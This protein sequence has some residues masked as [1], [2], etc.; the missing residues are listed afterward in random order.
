MIRA[1]DVDAA[2]AALADA[3]FLAP[4]AEAAELAAA[5]HDADELKAL[6]ARRR[7]GEPLAWITG[8]TTF[9]G[10]TIRVDPGVYVPRPQTEALAE[11]AVLLLPPGGVAVDLCTGSGAIAA[12]LGRR[13]PTA[14]VVASDV[15]PAAVACARA[16]GVD[17]RLGDLAQ[18][19]PSEVIG[20][21]DVV[22]GVVPY[23]P[24]ETLHLLPRDV[25]A[26]EPA[27]ALDGG[28]GGTEVLDR[29]IGAA[30][31]LLRPGGH[32]VLELGGDQDERLGPALAR[33][34]FTEVRSHR[35]E[36]GDLRHL[37]ARSPIHP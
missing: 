14:R 22:T 3:G 13:R 12:V 2:I 35:D 9:C 16:N 32:L 15:D 19:L 33:R 1:T 10:E 37:A 20:R 30:A 23:V 28:P 34:R 24:T 29:A 27:V 17:A 7:T 18:P 25:Q 4:E 26:H 8:S 5:A 6:V 31:R 21:A 36:D 11:A